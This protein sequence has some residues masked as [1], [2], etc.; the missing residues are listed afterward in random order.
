[1]FVFW[2][3]TIFIN[4]MQINAEVDNMKRERDERT[5]EFVETYPP[6]KFIDAIE[7]LSGSATTQEIADEVGCAYRTAHAKLSNMR[8][9]DLVISRR[10]GRSILWSLEQ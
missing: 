7:S 3:N 8:E 2:T 9:E 6:S 1:M 4:L 5:G 10:V